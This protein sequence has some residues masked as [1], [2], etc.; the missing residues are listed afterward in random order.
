MKKKTLYCEYAFNC[1]REENCLKGEFCPVF[2]LNSNM[3]TYIPQ[4][5]DFFEKCMDDIWEGR[6]ETKDVC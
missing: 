1:D 3:K 6:K 2:E 5:E 4:E